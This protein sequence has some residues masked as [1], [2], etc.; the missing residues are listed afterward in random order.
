M[1]GKEYNDGKGAEVGWFAATP[2]LAALK[3]QVSDA[4]IQRPGRPRRS[5]MLS[6]VARAY[7]EAPVKKEICIELPEED[8]EPED[9]PEDLVGCFTKAFMAPEMPQPTSSKR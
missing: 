7:F 9:G 4:A 1:F 2:P 6:D 8:W 3:L 5:M